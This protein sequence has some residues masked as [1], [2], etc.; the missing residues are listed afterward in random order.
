MFINFIFCV[1]LAFSCQKQMVEEKL[2]FMTA[3]ETQ[4][5]II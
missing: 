5:K 4:R 3:K 1:E 2:K